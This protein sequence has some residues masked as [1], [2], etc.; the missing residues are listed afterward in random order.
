[1]NLDE[2]APYLFLVKNQ[3]YIKTCFKEGEI[4]F[5]GNQTANFQSESYNSF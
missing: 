2:K 1:M 5:C 4:D 3:F